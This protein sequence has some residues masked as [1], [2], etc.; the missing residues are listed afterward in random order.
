MFLPHLDE[1][2]E[3]LGRLGRKKTHTSYTITDNDKIDRRHRTVANCFPK[4]DIKMQL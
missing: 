2:K 4:N 3:W 1:E